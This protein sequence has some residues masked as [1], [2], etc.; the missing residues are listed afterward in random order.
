VTNTVT[1]LRS[2]YNNQK[3]A[4]LVQ[5]YLYSKQYLMKMFE[6]DL[7]EYR[8][9]QSDHPE[10]NAE[11]DSDDENE[12]DEESERPNRLTTIMVALK[13][14]P[15]EQGCSEN[16]VAEKF[17]HKYG[18]TEVLHCLRKRLNALYHVIQKGDAISSKVEEDCVTVD[19]VKTFIAPFIRRS[20]VPFAEGTDAEC[21]PYPL[22]EKII[23]ASKSEVL[24]KGNTLRDAP[25]IGDTNKAHVHRAYLALK[26]ADKILV[27]AEMKRCLAKP[28]LFATIKTALKRRGPGNVLLALTHSA[29]CFRHAHRLVS[30]T[31][32]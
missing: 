14:L 19:A 4:Y 24:A 8:Q 22:V 7:R 13:L 2:C 21:C 27:V 1:E 25:G 3:L 11:D 18:D 30:S 23:I 15:Q 10:T 17:L 20:S 5:I 29:V 12:N 9:W 32:S 28:E 6:D 16:E 31:S 26:N